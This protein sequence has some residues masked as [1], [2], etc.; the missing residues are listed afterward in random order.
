LSIGGNG[1]SHPT[2]SGAAA[3]GLAQVIPDTGAYIAQR[4]ASPDFVNEDLYKPYVGLAFGGYYLDQQLRAFNGFT[5]AALSAYN[6]GPGNDAIWYEQAG[7]DQ[8]LYLE[9]VYFAETRLYI[10]RIYTGYVVYRFL[11]VG[12]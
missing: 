12:K 11:Y 4:L 10:E 2:R 9:T 8:D 1:R 6:A 7:A 3:Q 5:A